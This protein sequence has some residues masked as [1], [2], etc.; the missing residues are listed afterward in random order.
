MDFIEAVIFTFLELGKEDT[1]ILQNFR[2][3]ARSR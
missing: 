1:H 2:H 3:P